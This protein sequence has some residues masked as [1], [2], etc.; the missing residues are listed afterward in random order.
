MGM[1]EFKKSEGGQYNPVAEGT[2]D[3]EIVEVKQGAS[4]G[5]HMQV[6]LLTQIVGGP[7]DGR[8][9]RMWYIITEKSGWKIQKLLE[10]VGLQVQDAGN[11]NLAFDPDELNGCVFTA[12]AKMAKTPD[13]RD[14][15]EFVNERP[16]KLAAQ[17]V[18]AA[19]AQAAP[20]PAPAPVAPAAAPSMP[21][22][23]PRG[24]R[25]AS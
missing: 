20:Q 8:K 16:S 22:F 3:F 13:G 5:G 25:R 9:V 7:E 19:A 23:A 6:E 21:G 12:D 11:G 4:S 18:D 10:A 15:N 24:A 1:I 2:Y 17:P 14:K